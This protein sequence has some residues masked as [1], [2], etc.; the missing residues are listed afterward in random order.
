MIEKVKKIVVEASHLMATDSFEIEEKD[1]MSNIVTSSDVAVQD[2]LC[3]N[4]SALLPGSGFLCEEK[5]IN[6][7]AQEHTWIIDP[8]D[9]TANYSRGIAQCAVC[10]GLRKDN[11]MLLGI[12]YVPLTGE[13]FFAE[14]GKG[15]FL[16]IIDCETKATLKPAKRIKVSGRPFGNALLCTALPVYHKEHAGVCSD[17]ISEAFPQINDLRR[18]GACAPELCYVAMG[19]CEMYFEYI[20]SPWDYAAASLILTEAGGIITD[21]EGN[22]V[23]CVT[24][25]GLIAG[26]SHENHQKLLA[27]VRRHYRK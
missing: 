26:N 12:V 24:P 23:T 19:R 16:E 18:F 4:L 17:I 15:A 2:F 11:A 8:I 9:G 21:L 22:A 10:V 6:D 13:L 27:I 5:D 7:L 14:K 1:G 20:L 25:C 3:K